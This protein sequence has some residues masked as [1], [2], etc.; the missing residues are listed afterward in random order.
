MAV[1]EDGKT[2]KIFSDTSFQKE[3]YVVLFFFPMDRSVDYSELM[4]FK[5]H[6]EQFHYSGCQ[7]V[8]VTSDSTESIINWI[9]MKPKQGGTGG[10]LNFPIISDKNLDLADMFGVKGNSGIPPRATFVLDKERQV[11]HVSVYPRVVARCVREVARTVQAIREVDTKKKDNMEVAI[12]A[13]WRPGDKM[14]INTHEGRKEYYKELVKEKEEKKKVKETVEDDS[15]NI[16][17]NK[18][19]DGDESFTLTSSPQVFCP[20]TNWFNKVPNQDT[21]EDLFI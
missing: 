10:P 16:T 15:K 1:M 18:N 21:V 13:N 11:R 17:E 19:V 5:E 7:V 2:C 9:K 3:K 14:I 20:V 12:P 8:G 6:V 4:A